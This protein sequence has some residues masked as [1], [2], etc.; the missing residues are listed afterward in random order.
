MY[1]NNVNVN[2]NLYI[3]LFIFYL[4]IYIEMSY[5]KKQPKHTRTL[6][7]NTDDA[8]YV[9]GDRKTFTFR[10]APINIEDESLMYVKNTVANFKTTGLAVKS[11][12]S[13]LFLG[14]TAT[15]SST[16]SVQPAITFASQDGKGS[17]ASAIGL[18]APSGL[19]GSATS[20]TLSVNVINAGSGYTGVAGDYVVNAVVPTTG[21]SGAT[22]TSGTLTTA[23]GSFSPTGTLVAG[24][25]YTEVPLFVAPI[26]PASVPATFN[27]AGITAG[28]ITTAPSVANPTLNGFYNAS[29]FVAS[30][31]SGHKIALGVVNTN[32]SGTVT[33]ISLDNANDNGYYDS[34]FPL[35]V[36]SINGI[37]LGTGFGTG[38]VIAP[39]YSGGK[40]ASVVVTNGGTGYGANLVNGPIQFSFPSIG[41]GATITGA[42][43]SQ[44]RIT[45]ITLGAGGT[46]YYA[47]TV[48]ITAGVVVPVQATYEPVFKIGSVIAGVRMLTH[49]AGYTVPP[50]PLISST[51]RISNAGDLPLIAE[52]APTYLVEKNNYYI[53][54]ADGFQFNRTLYTNTDNKGLP[55]IAVC[56]TNEE[57]ND[58]DYTELVL[59]AQVLDN[60]TI[61]I[62][63]KDALGLETN[64]N[65]IILLTIEELDK[66]E[67]N[68]KDSKR[69]EY[70]S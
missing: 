54:K 42:T 16:Y 4:L 15:F 70:I 41:T 7:L 21:G 3:F 69:Q 61:T 48:S 1:N 27:S 57:V 68:F 30:F 43:V 36:V 29:T 6:I 8:N 19:S 59:P 24:S 44:G 11:V 53:V 50:K 55:T 65:M 46:K 40:C 13:G 58:E 34:S 22:I 45:A 67:T 5:Y 26:P 2:V 18:L 9:D 32:A 35:T 63:D 31:V 64:R 28:V 33:S 62:H 23:T 38:L 52:I 56:S 39:T 20:S 14:S 12:Q 47:P 10:F 66:N 37:Q 17:G 49:G 60:I 51:N 25:G